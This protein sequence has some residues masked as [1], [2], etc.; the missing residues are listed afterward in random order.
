MLDGTR[1]VPYSP[2]GTE[3]TFLLS[4]KRIVSVELQG[5]FKAVHYWFLSTVLS[6][7]L[8]LS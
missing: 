1:R 8:W 6:L 4:N 3:L 2:L 7:P 5:P